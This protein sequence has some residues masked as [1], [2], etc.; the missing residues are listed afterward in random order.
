MGISEKFFK[1]GII[2]IEAQTKKRHYKK[3]RKK[4]KRL[5]ITPTLGH[6]IKYR[7]IAT[8]IEKICEINR[9]EKGW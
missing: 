6:I 8:R 9:H 7:K 5:E 3:R 2:K 4:K 1:E